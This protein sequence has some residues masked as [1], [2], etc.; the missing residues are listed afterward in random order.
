MSSLLFVCLNPLKRRKGSLEGPRRERKEF[1]LPC[2]KTRPPAKNLPPQRGRVGTKYGGRPSR[3]Q[4]GLHEPLCTTPA[5]LLCHSSRTP[6]SALKGDQGEP[7]PYIPPPPPLDCPPR[8]AQGIGVPQGL[9]GVRIADFE[10]VIWL[11][12]GAGGAFRRCSER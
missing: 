5:G 7:S 1:T 9:S 11:S 2:P 4:V 8:N 10:T 3:N 6:I 12:S